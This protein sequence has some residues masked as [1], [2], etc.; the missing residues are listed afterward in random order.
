MMQLRILWLRFTLAAV[1][2]GFSRKL[3]ELKVYRGTPG[4]DDMVRLGRSAVKSLGTPRLL[5]TDH[6]TV[7]ADRFTA[8]IENQGITIVKGK[9][10]QPSF[11]GKIERLLGTI[12]VWLRIALLPISVRPLQRRLDNYAAWFNEHRLHAALGGCTPDEAWQGI[13]LPEAIPIR[14]TDPDEIV[15]QVQRQSYRSDPALPIITIRVDRK[16]AA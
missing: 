3:L 8:I 6:G 13:D 7:F 15:V 4:T 2:D 16:E 9:V 10:R 1:M 12:R 14:P 5:I 11:N